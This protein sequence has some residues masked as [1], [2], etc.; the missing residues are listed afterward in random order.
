MF[1][2]TR[3][4]LWKCWFSASQTVGVLSQICQVREG[5]LLSNQAEIGVSENGLII[6]PN[7]NYHR[8]TD[9]NPLE[10]QTPYFQSSPN[11]ILMNFGKRLF[12]TTKTRL[13]KVELLKPDFGAGLFNPVV[14]SWR[15][16]AYI[17][18]GD[19]FCPFGDVLFWLFSSVQK[20]L[21]PVPTGLGL[22]IQK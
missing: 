20:S 10:L 16:K 22:G 3:G 5:H 8:E 18:H 12:V 15:A 2:D 6:L 11:I 9:D 17:G 19:G 21:S 13:I 7:S 1:E 14:G 4:Q